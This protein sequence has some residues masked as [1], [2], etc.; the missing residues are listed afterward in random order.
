MTRRFLNNVRTDLNTVLVTGGDTTADELRP[1]LIDM[2]D[3]TIQDECAIYSTVPHAGV[4]VGTSWTKI[5]NDT[6]DTSRGGDGV[7]LKPSFASGDIETASTAGFSYNVI[8]TISFYGGNNDMYEFS[9]GENGTPVGATSSITGQGV[10]TLVSTTV[11][12]QINAA[13][14]DALYS[15]YAQSSVASD[16][17]DIA[18]CQLQVTVVPTNNA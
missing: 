15:L 12:Y 18:S 14:S 9:I 10:N 11:F 7:F 1:L 4:S 8:A 17:I 3:S 2:I 16:T 5:N 6:Y 13:P